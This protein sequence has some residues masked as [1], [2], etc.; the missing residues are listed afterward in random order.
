VRDHITG[1]RE[2]LV[3]AR[4]YAIIYADPA[5]TRGELRQSVSDLNQYCEQMVTAMQAI[6]GVEAA[7]EE[8]ASLR[9]LYHRS[10]VGEADAKPT[11]REFTE[12]AQSL[13]ALAPT[14]SAWEGAR[15]P[16]T[17]CSTPTGRLIGID[18]FDRARISS[19][20][21]SVLGQPGSGKS[22]MMARIIND[23]LA[24]L[25][26]ARVRAVDFGESL[27]PHV[28]VTG[29]QAPQVQRRRHQDY[30]HLGLPRY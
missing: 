7:R 11:G 12:V 9:S 20:L 17:L 27:A 21:V 29:G 4:F 23:V 25:P 5:R 16:H 8:P 18:L 19:P 24:T 2:A 26:E 22:T 1:S 10:L 6:P 30:K 3:E 13:A 28:D 15:R 14:E